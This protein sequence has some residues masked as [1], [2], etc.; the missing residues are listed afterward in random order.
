MKTLNLLL[1]PLENRRPWLIIFSAWL[2]TIAFPRTGAWP[3]A[4]IALIPFLFV[5]DEQKPLK[6]FVTGYMTGLL[7][8][9]AMFYWFIHVTILGTVLFVLYLAVYFGLFA[10]GYSLFS[11]FGTFLKLFLLPSL[12]VVLEYIREHLFT[13]FGWGSLG[14]SQYTNLFVIQFADITGVAGVSFL[15]L[16]FNYA[17]KEFLDVSLWQKSFKPN[18]DSI[19]PLVVVGLFLVFAFSYSSVRM[20]TSKS[21]EEMSVGIVQGNIA[22]KL[23]WNPLVWPDILEKYVNLTEEVAKSKPDVIFWPETALPGYHWETP[24]LLETV[25]DLVRDIKIPLLVGLVTREG[26]DYLNDAFLLSAKGRVVQK[27]SKLH[28]VPFGEY[29]PLRG[30]FP[31]L[32]D[33]VPIDDFTPGTEATVFSVTKGKSERPRKF[34][35]LIC[36]EDGVSE[37]ARRFVQKGAGALV[38][39]TNDAWFLNTRA[40][41][42]H[43][44]ASVFRAIENRRTV[45]RAA[46]TGVSCFIDEK[47]KASNYVQNDKGQKTFVDGYAVKNIKL[48]SEKTFYTKFG[49]VFT[50]LCFGCILLG[51][52]AILINISIKRI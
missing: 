25:K 22:Q 45:V 12:W 43:V 42:L 27:Y 34:S 18:R 32:T 49:D 41:F 2:L 4:W 29:V 37:I 3:F 23:K 36:F 10:A 38:N 5:L 52:I 35:V 14:Y 26:E 6:A 46:N 9:G 24:I 40:P 39:I 8:F 44:Q 33:I 11:R 30:R 28:L 15:V 50:Y 47:G 16:M 19:G 1:E 51:M 17:L 20:T 31:I 13:G 48:G 21:T 7:F